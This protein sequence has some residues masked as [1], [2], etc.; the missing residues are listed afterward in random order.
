MNI[1]FH[2]GLFL[3]KKGWEFFIKS[4][5]GD[6]PYLFFLLVA[7]FSIRISVGLF[8][9][10]N[11]LVSWIKKHSTVEVE[12]KKNVPDSVIR[13][14]KQELKDINYSLKTPTQALAEL[15][16]MV[17]SEALKGIKGSPFGYI[18]CF[19]PGSFQ[20]AAKVFKKYRKWIYKRYF[21]TGAYE[22][23]V[24]MR[25]T[26]IVLT[27]LISTV[28]FFSSVFLFFSRFLHV[29]GRG[30]YF[31]ETTKMIGLPFSLSVVP[32]LVQ[33]MLEM[34][35]ALIF[36]FPLAELFLNMFWPRFRPFPFPRMP[37]PGEYV[38]AGVLAVFMIPVLLIPFVKKEIKKVL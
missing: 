29:M 19:E 38:M 21:P 15:E 27:F 37:L 8:W 13:K 30:F 18:F 22:A 2:R 23:S 3:I 28:L 7:F 5:P 9:Q 25:R 34:L 16:K 11:Q 17:G 14:I 24:R 31:I 6:L 12:L 32:F 1:K 4:L 26:L 33:A 20:K 36:A 10:L 35:M